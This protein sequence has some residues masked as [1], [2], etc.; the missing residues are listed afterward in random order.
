ML[1]AYAVERA[2]KKVGFNHISVGIGSYPRHIGG[3]LLSQLY[4]VKVQEDLADN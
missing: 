3:F 4:R 1:L 2:S